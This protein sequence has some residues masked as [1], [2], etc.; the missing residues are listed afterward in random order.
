[1]RHNGLVF[2]ETL[3]ESCARATS[4][5]VPVK[6]CEGREVS[7]GDDYE[8]I[9]AVPG[10]GEVSVLAHEAHGEHLDAHL[11]REEGEDQVVEHLHVPLENVKT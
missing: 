5:A 1:M 11:E 9:E 6:R 3:A 2:Y 7:P 4:K 10:L 8:E